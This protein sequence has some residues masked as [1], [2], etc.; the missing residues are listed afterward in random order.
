MLVACDI[1][2][3]L[4][5]IVEDGKK[6]L[7]KTPKD[8]EGYYQRIPENKSIP[9]VVDAVLG[10]I[11][12]G[13]KILLVTGRPEKVRTPT[14]DWLRNLG[15]LD[16]S[17]QLMMNPNAGSVSGQEYKLNLYRKLKPYWIIEDEPVTVN[18]LVKE[19]FKV[20][21]VHGYRWNTREDAKPYV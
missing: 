8:W 19:G 16:S 1:D 6:Y 10:L 13:Y 7:C 14:E 5:D 18:A 20:L 17:D 21:Q 3:C 11:Q 2:G 4:A 9:L 15:L 12:E